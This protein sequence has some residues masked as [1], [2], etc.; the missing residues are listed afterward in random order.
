MDCGKVLTISSLI[1][2][3]QPLHYDLRSGR[4]CG[5]TSALVSEAIVLSCPSIY[6]SISGLS[7]FSRESLFCPFRVALFSRSLQIWQHLFIRHF[8]RTDCHDITRVLISCHTWFMVQSCVVPRYLMDGLCLIE[9]LQ[10]HWEYVKWS[11]AI[12]KWILPS[13]KPD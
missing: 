12:I 9:R 10:F 3:H 13:V 11:I 6:P 7:L 5:W 4:V 2:P 1:T 8:S